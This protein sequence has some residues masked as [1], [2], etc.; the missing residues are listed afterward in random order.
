MKD[1]FRG[2]VISLAGALIFFGAAFWVLDLGGIWSFFLGALVY[3]GLLLL[4]KPRRRLGGIDVEQIPG[5][6]QLEEKLMEAREDFRR[7]GAAMEAIQDDRL[8]ESSREL[9][10]KAGSIL[11]YLVEHPGK[12]MEARRFIDY[13]QDTASS[14]LEKYVKLQ[15][16]GLGSREAERL[17]VQTTQALLTLNRAF[18]GQFEKLMGNEL[19][20]MEAEIRL[21]KQTMEMEG[22]EEENH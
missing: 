18:E 22:Y 8:R 21:L 20:D 15:E 4:T 2:M 7:I 6:E 16:T 1:E 11:K 17:K 12:I 9:H 13:Y 10:K 19:M 5:G 3:G 14:L